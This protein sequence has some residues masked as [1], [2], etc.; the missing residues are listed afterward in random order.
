MTCRQTDTGLWFGASVV[1]RRRPAHGLPDRIVV[2]APALERFGVGS[3]PEQP[4]DGLSG[5]VRAFQVGGGDPLAERDAIR[6]AA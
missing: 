2:A 4:F 5:V 6:L 1:A 3:S